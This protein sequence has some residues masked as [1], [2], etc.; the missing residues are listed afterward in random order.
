MLSTCPW[1]R[2]QW[3][4]AVEAVPASAVFPTHMPIKETLTIPFEAASFGA[5]ASLILAGGGEGHGFFLLDHLYCLPSRF[6]LCGIILAVDTPTVNALSPTPEA[7]TV[8][9]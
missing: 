8:H 6:M 5:F 9:L 3:G 4:F 1:L 7:L 2:F